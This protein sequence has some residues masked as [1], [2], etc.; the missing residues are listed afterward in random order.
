MGQRAPRECSVAEPIYYVAESSRDVAESGRDA[1]ESS[2]DSSGSHRDA[3][4]RRS[5]PKMYRMCEKGSRKG[6]KVYVTFV[7]TNFW[8]AD[9]IWDL[10]RRAQGTLRERLESESLET[11]HDLCKMSGLPLSG[12]KI[13]VIERL[14]VGNIDPIVR[15][16]VHDYQRIDLQAACATAALSISGTEYNLAL[17]LFR[18]CEQ[19]RDE[20]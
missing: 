10:L 3:A 4:G 13:D 7:E 14:A 5:Y 12:S 20:Q 2:Q 16:L 17:R 19:E 8:I 18:R 9:E 1:A 15:E 6:H 11:L